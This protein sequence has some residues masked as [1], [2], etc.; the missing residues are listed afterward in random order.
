M[1][2][3]H[4]IALHEGAHAILAIE[5]GIG[6]RGVTIVPSSRGI[7][8]VFGLTRSSAEFYV[9][10]VVCETLRGYT[11]DAVCE[12]SHDLIA[13]RELAKPGEDEAAIRFAADVLTRRMHTVDAIAELLL[14]RGSVAYA[15]IALLARCMPPT[16][17]RHRW[18]PETWAPL[19]ERIR[20]MPQATVARKVDDSDDPGVPAGTTGTGNHK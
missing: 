9:A 14:A 8:R 19:L 6:F 15:E 16:Q 5:L 10:G 11:L 4:R 20:A 2:D 13:V 1:T 12:S 17:S 18:T 3:L 7:A